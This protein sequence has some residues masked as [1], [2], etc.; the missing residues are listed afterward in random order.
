MALCLDDRPFHPA[1]L[2]NVPESAFFLQLFPR[3]GQ[4]FPAESRQINAY[5]FFA[6]SS[7]KLTQTMAGIP[8]SRICRTRFKF[9]S[10]QVESQITTAA[11]QFPKQMRPVQALLQQSEP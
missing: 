6:A 11:S 4:K 1:G 7:M 3:Q 2:K 5:V 9:R 10:R 8:V